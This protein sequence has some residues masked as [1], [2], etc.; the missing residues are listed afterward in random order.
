MHNKTNCT[1]NMQKRLHNVF[2][3]YHFHTSEILVFGTFI[4][5]NNN[6]KKGNDLNN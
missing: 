6:N 3:L 4:V 2:V 5:Y 1:K